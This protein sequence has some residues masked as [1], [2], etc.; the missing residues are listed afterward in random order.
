MVTL[1]VKRL[2]GYNNEE[3]GA[4]TP[5][6]LNTTTL[7][8]MVMSEVDSS[9]EYRE[10]PGFP[11]YRVGSD[12]SVWTK[13]H[14]RHGFKDTW[15]IMRPRL[16]TGRGKYQHV[17][18]LG[19]T[20]KVHRLVM[21]AFHGHH[22]ELLVRH[23]DNDTGNNRLT[24][25]CYGT[26]KDNVHDSI[27]H[28]RFNLRWIKLTEAK[29]RRI[30]LAAAAGEKYISIATRFGICTSAVGAIV[31]GK[32]WPYAGGPIMKLKMKHDKASGRFIRETSSH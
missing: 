23:M 15:R 17:K 8:E 24:N 5:R 22:P 30:R 1:T 14:G 7:L 25:L 19:K 12:G 31:N 6:P 16:G 20:M 29:V 28:R 21:M 11:G 13:K 9:V 4:V 3:R 26:Q 18:M 10:V 27:K 2:G 32:T